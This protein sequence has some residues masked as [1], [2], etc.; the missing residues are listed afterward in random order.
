MNFCKGSV[1]DMKDHIVI[2]IVENE[3][4]NSLSADSTRQ[5]RQRSLS[6]RL[7]LNLKEGE[8][9]SYTQ[10]MSGL[11]LEQPALGSERL[12]HPDIVDLV[13]KLR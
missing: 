7:S 2:C 1:E 4:N 11:Q 13:I 6:F 9:N 5:Y 12:H 8:A 3:D 10:L